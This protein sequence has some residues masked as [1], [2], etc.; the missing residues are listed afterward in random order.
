MTNVESQVP[1]HFTWIV[2]C[3]S[4]DCDVSFHGHARQVDAAKAW[5]TRISLGPKT[6][7]ETTAD[8][9]RNGF[10]MPLKVNDYGDCVVDQEGNIVADFTLNGDPDWTDYDLEMIVNHIADAIN[11]YTPE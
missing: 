11:A 3:D 10:V 4:E 1:G 8:I 6:L 7:S 2:G 5:N 9:F